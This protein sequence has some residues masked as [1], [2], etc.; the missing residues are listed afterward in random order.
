MLSS[1]GAHSTAVVSVA[2]CLI[3]GIA[4]ARVPESKAKATKEFTSVN[5]QAMDAK[6]TP[7]K[8]LGIRLLSVECWCKDCPPKTDCKCCPDQVSGK[9]DLDGRWSLSLFPGT[10]KIEVQRKGAKL[11]QREV[12]IGKGE[13]KSVAI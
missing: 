12:T 9:T 13:N 11:V 7:A 5:V 6:E 3:S 10:Y 1:R 4:S 2:L 8:N